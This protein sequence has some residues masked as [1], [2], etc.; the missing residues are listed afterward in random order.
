MKKS[1]PAALVA[2]A[3]LP[4]CVLFGIYSYTTTVRFTEIVQLPDGGEVTVKRKQ[5]IKKENYLVGKDEYAVK[6]QLII[7][8]PITGKELTAWENKYEDEPYFLY[9]DD[10]N[11]YFYLISRPRPV[12]SISHLKKIGYIKTYMENGIRYYEP[13]VIAYCLNQSQMVWEMVSVPEKVIG[14]KANIWINH[15]A[16]FSSFT[17]KEEVG[18]PKNKWS[19]SNDGTIRRRSVD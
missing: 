10:E 16:R 4:G 9:R 11:C 7:I 1:L 15:K 19:S 17:I 18:K 14:Q 5:W 2:A 12:W 13:T 8:D 3:V 6:E